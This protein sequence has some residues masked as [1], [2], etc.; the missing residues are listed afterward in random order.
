MAD[1]TRLNAILWGAALGDA[2]GATVRG[3]SLHQIKAAYGL[4]GVRVLPDDA[5]PGPHTAQLL[6]LAA[7]KTIQPV[8]GGNPAACVAGLAYINHADDA[9]LF[10]ALADVV[11]DAQPATLAATLAA[12]YMVAATMQGIHVNEY[13][14]K[15]MTFCDGISD[16]FDTTLLRIGHVLGWVDEDAA[17]KHIGTGQSPVDTVVMALYCVL[18]YDDDFIACVGRAATTD[19]DSAAIA[20]IAGAIMGV[21]LGD[22]NLLPD[23]WIARLDLDI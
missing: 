13:V 4:Q 6:T 5:Q 3:L 16:V 11:P 22:V 15:T 9:A 7:D 19:G 12:G 17:L 1:D 20:A 23:A 18:R 21:R 8:M 14:N 10:R 2:L